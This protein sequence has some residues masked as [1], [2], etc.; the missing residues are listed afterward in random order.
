MHHLKCI[1]NICSSYNMMAFI[2]LEKT[3]SVY[4]SKNDLNKPVLEEHSQSLV[5]LKA[6]LQKKLNND[7]ADIALYIL[8]HA[9]WYLDGD[10]NRKPQICK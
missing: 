3:T 9:K 7:T 5:R 2:Y 8:R 1:Q 10:V 4:S 6:N